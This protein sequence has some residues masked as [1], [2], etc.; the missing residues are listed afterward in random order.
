MLLY[1]PDTP[2]ATF[3]DATSGV[4]VL[5]VLFGITRTRYLDDPDHLFA[6]MMATTVRFNLAYLMPTLLER[7][8]SVPELPGLFA[9]KAI[10]DRPAAMPLGDNDR[11][12]TT[13]FFAPDEGMSY[14][15]SFIVAVLLPE[16]AEHAGLTTDA[17]LLYMYPI[18]DLAS[19]VDRLIRHST[20]P[21]RPGPAPVYDIRAR[22][23]AQ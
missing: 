4:P 13:P 14:I 20:G 3:C 16:R 9:Q 15:T 17:G 2:T 12:G 21:D 23:P 8:R 18:D 6:S 5:D 11:V 7:M 19:F 1:S 22:P 10:M